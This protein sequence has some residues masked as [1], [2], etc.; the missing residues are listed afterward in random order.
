MTKKRTDQLIQEVTRDL[1]ALASRE[2]VSA[3]LLVKL[4]GLMMGQLK[5]LVQLIPASKLN[6][7]RPQ[8]VRRMLEIRKKL[9]PPVGLV[10]DVA[11][12]SGADLDTLVA[13]LGQQ[14]ASEED[15]QEA[16]CADGLS[17][18]KVRAVMEGQLVR[19][20][21]EGADGVFLIA[22]EDCNLMFRGDLC[23]TTEQG[24]RAGRLLEGE[25]PEKAV[26]H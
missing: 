3:A 9:S 19:S 22:L 26:T 1:R 6:S 17:F 12:Q 21:T 23:V 18:E 13:L 10:V 8:V 7:V 2:N 25:M 11:I 15:A 5:V 20:V 16:E 4:V 14:V 24:T